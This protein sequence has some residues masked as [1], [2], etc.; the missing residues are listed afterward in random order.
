MTI[1]PIDP[2][3]PTEPRYPSVSR[4]AFLRGSAG[5]GLAALAAPALAACSGSSSSTTGS[6]PPATTTGAVA[7]PDSVE[8]STSADA[9]TTEA[10]TAPDVGSG[11]AFADGR[12][13]QVDFTYHAAGGGRV[14]SPYIAVWI[15]DPSGELVQTVSLWYKSDER[16]YLK[17]LKRWNSKNSSDA[18]TTGATRIPGSF[19]VAWNGTDLGGGVAP[20]GEYFVCVEAARE[21]GPYQI[22]RESVSI[23]DALAPT[24]L[25]PNGELIAASTALVA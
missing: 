25:T 11:A 3:D 15:E 10:A 21:D 20:D 14:H 18:L 8:P 9:A 17:D 4:R 12:Q 1:N 13:L 16:K 23:S 22:I 7:P 2:I 6:N 19:S 5:V 24:A